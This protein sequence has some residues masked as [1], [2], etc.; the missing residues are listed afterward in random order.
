MLTVRRTRGFTPIEL[1][2]VVLCVAVLAALALPSFQAQIRKGRRADGLLALAQVQQAQERYRSSHPVYAPT[3]ADLALPATSPAGHYTLSLSI[4]PATQGQAYGVAAAASGPQ[5]NDAACRHLRVVV[6][7]GVMSTQSGPTT[8]YANG[9]A[10][11]RA[12][13]PQ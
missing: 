9:T 13:W 4:D 5:A 12:C 2:V 6:Q 7:G 11:N 3:L 1:M 10:D 8:A